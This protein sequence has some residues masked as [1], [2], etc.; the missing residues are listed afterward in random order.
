MTAEKEKAITASELTQELQGT[1]GQR[2]EEEK[3]LV[4]KLLPGK[5]PTVLFTGF[6]TGKFIRSAQNAIA[7]NYRVRR[8]RISKPAT[9][10]TSQ[11]NQV[12]PNLGDK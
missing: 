11:E 4:V 5:R 8:A 1:A 9:E 10:V 12:T 3:T 7:K 2:N 6:W